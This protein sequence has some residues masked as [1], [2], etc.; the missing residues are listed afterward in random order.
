MADAGFERYWGGEMTSEQRARLEV[1][2]RL[3]VPDLWPDV[4]RRRIGEQSPHGPS[5]PARVIIA[6]V[7][8]LIAGSSFLLLVGV[9]PSGNR[10]AISP[11][12]SVTAW[13]GNGLIYFRSQVRTEVPT[14]WQAISSDGMGLRTVF[15]ASGSFVPDHLAFSP[16]GR[17]V[18]VNVVGQPGIWVADVDGTN[19]MQLTHGANDAWPAWSPDGTKIAFAGRPD[20]EPCPPDV[21]YYGCARDL[22]IVNSDGTGLRMVT[23]GAAAPAW[24]PD[25]DRIAFQTSGGDGGTAIVV[26][27]ADGSGEAVLARTPQGSDIAPAWSPDGGTIVYASIRNED[28]GIYAVPATGGPERTL[29]PAGHSLGYVDDPT[30]S[31]DGKLIAF[32]ADSGIGVM[33]PDGS[34]FTQLVA[35]HGRYPAGAIAWQPVPTTNT[36]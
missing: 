6:A 5:R 25:G 32:V 36:Q 20:S 2:D 4:M 21:F 29:I 35:Q 28:W 23:S 18:A 12:P 33:R 22:H 8:L 17:R 3:Q 30:W 24:S 15:P 1:F 31:P 14:R 26:V 10:P 34:H 9:W 19:A 16:D 27:N 7:A 11:N 13:F